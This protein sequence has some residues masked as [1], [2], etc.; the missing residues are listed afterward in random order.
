MEH[1]DEQQTTTKNTKSETTKTHH[2]LN[3]THLKNTSLLEQETNNQTTQKN[4]EQELPIIKKDINTTS[5]QRIKPYSKT[6]LLKKTNEQVVDDILNTMQKNL[7]LAKQDNDKPIL[8]NFKS[9]LYNDN[10]KAFHLEII[11]RTF[12]RR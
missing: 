9:Y 2:Q 1:Q 7:E 6:E 8:H 12:K 10:N 11:R 3:H 4:D 5:N